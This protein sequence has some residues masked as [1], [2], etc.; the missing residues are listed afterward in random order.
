M[1]VAYLINQYPKVSHTFIR[2]EIETLEALGWEVLRFAVRDCES[3]LVDETDHEEVAKTRYILQSGG[4][5][6]LSSFLIILLTRSNKFLSTLRQT[7]KIGWK[8]ERGLLIHLIYLAEACLL[9]RWLKSENVNL[10]HCHFGTNST[11]VAMICYWLGGPKYSFTVHGPEEFDKVELIAL[12]TKIN[13]AAFVVAIS[14]FGRSQLFRWCPPEQWSKI[15]VVRCGLAA[16]FLNFPFQTLPPRET[17]KLVCVGRLTP[18]KGHFLL[19][20]SIGKLISKNYSCQ[21]TLVG[22]GELRPVI[23][24]QIKELELQDYIQITGWA[25]N[26]TVRKIIVESHLFVLP[27]FAEGLPVVLMESLAL[28]RPVIST[29]MAGIPE[30]VEVGKCG[31][32]VAAGSEEALTNTL[33][34]ALQASSQTLESMG[35]AGATRVK[36][37]HSINKEVKKL[38]S[39]FNENL[40][41]FN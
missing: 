32:L 2:R 37:L 36:E 30:L 19:L 38:A 9:L 25:S 23:E 7:I 12:P 41:S 14:H 16:D 5:T 4:M 20:N 10:I 40:S 11:T 29:Y 34:T 1:R 22:D 26:S 15:Y 28:S 35:K 24:K 33:E 8:S 39:L 18:Q 31:W 17:I 3:E 27:S 21:V 6:L 13:H